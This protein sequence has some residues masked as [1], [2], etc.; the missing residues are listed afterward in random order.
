[1]PA[2]RSFG[3]QVLSRLL[4]AGYLA[5]HRWPLLLGMASVLL[6][7]FAYWFTETGAFNRV[8][9]AASLALATLAFIAIQEKSGP[10][11]LAR[12]VLYSIACLLIYQLATKIPDVLAAGPREWDF[13]CFFLDAQVVS[14][15]LNLYQ[16]DSYVQVTQALNI[17]VSGDFERE[18]LQ[19]GFKYPPPSAM[20]FYP[21]SRFE[22]EQASVVWLTV[23]VVTIFAACLAISLLIVDKNA[24]THVNVKF[25]D[26]FSFAAIVVLTLRQTHLNVWLGQTAPLLCVL[27]V[28]TILSSGRVWSGIAASLS[29]F[30][31][32]VAA[33]PALLL[34]LGKYKAGVVAGVV[35]GLSL[36]AI[37]VVW[38]GTDDW[39]VYLRQDYATTSPAWL[40]LQENN[41]SLLAVISRAFEITE[42][43]WGNVPVVASFSALALA[44]AAPGILL[45][46]RISRDDFRTAYCLLLLT[47]LIL[48]PGT[49]QSYGILLC[50]PIIVEFWNQHKSRLPEVVPILFVGMIGSLSSRY[51]FASTLVL[52]MVFALRAILMLGVI[53]VKRVARFSRDTNAQAK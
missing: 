26:A 47:G 28:V 44:F 35:A 24:I 33:I 1:M 30:V 29:V 20:I 40:Y 17:Q 22:I 25:I 12:I 11:L 5:T 46:T 10:A 18:I 42:V 32:P 23:V 3:E 31:K 8:A 34:L 14:A 19:V 13:L 53:D 48:Y 41:Q 50:I 49:Q 21:L 9:R 4:G 15:G 45:A 52:W 2:T 43:P 7:I 39:L 51:Q 6:L 38:L 27:I 16:P 36:I 37:S